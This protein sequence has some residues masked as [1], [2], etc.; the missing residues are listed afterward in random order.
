MPISPEYIRKIIHI[1]MDAFY[2]S[3]EQR[4]F[5]E[6]KGKPVAVGGSSQRGV[7]AAASY[8]ARKFGVR[9][10]MPSVTAARL[11]PDLVFVK[12]RFDVYREVSQQIR[13]IFLEYT[14]LVEPLSLDEAYLDVTENKKGIAAATQIA[15]E[16]RERIL[17]ETQLTASAGISIN[18][19][20][21]KVAT[22]INKPNGMTLIPPDRA[23]AFLE[24]LEIQKFYGIGAKTAE[25]MKRLGIFTGADLK[26]RSEVDL[27]RLFGKAGRHYF[28]I[29][30]ALDKRPVKPDR[31]RKSVGAEN[32]FSEDLNT[33]AEMISKLTPIVH[34]VA[35]RLGKADLAGRTVTLKIKYH[36]FVINTRS[37]SAGVFLATFEDLMPV[38]EALLHQPEFPPQ[39]VRLLGVSVSNLNHDELAGP[40]QLTLEF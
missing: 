3:V 8:E 11:C 18:K 22:D 31:Q 35:D 16:I 26:A 33:E 29:V 32:T 4:D 17:A 9:S 20:L 27:A 30:R 21:A 25:K 10:A 24:R 19:F 5:P 2:A 28:R 6:L 39:P 14:D 12:A 1:D 36:D 34:K 7:V 23:E 38:V 15:K 40:M 37:R 13:A